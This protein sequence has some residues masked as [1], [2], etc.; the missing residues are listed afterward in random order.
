MRRLT[1]L[2]AAGIALVA[3]LGGATAAQ[4]ACSGSTPATASFADSPFDG[5]A[6]L[7][8]EITTVTAALDA[9]CD[10]SVATGI[11]PSLIEGDA[12]F[13]YIDRDNNPGT[14]S[15]VFGGADV[16]VGTLGEIGPELPPV[17]GTWNG[18]EYVFNDPTPVGPARLDGGFVASVD[19]LGLASGSVTHFGVATIYSG[20]YD[21]YVDSAPE[22]GDLLPSLP[23]AYATTPPAP[24]VAPPSGPAVAPRPA[25]TTKTPTTSSCVVPKLRGKS[26]TTAEDRLF[27][28][29]CDVASSVRRAYSS[30][31]KRG[32]VIRTTPGAGARTSKAVKLVI[33]KGKR[34]RHAHAAAAPA[35]PSSVLDRLEA[36]ANAPRQ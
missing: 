14:G 8:P 28:A 13:V 34:K 27:A 16:V 9:A 5:D 15:A 11:D 23:V 29:D 12:V 30:S 36:L 35:V 20:I 21:D 25:P 3:L 18:A 10:Y 19:R 26:R 22:L 31:V 17:L 6:G 24:P 2:A 7:A 4:A 1:Y 32:R 33:S